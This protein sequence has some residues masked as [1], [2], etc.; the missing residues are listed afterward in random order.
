MPKLHEVLYERIK[1]FP[2]AVEKINGYINKIWKKI[3]R[4]PSYIQRL[5][6]F[7]SERNIPKLSISGIFKSFCIKLGLREKILENQYKIVEE[8]YK[9][10]GVNE[11]EIP[12]HLLVSLQIDYGQNRVVFNPEIDRKR[13]NL[14]KLVEI[15]YP[16]LYKEVKIFHKLCE[17]SAKDERVENLLEMRMKELIIS[18]CKNVKEF[19]ERLG[20]KP[21]IVDE[22]L[23]E[24]NLEK[25][26]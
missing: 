2:S 24:L 19:L 3:R 10:C 21:E 17:L 11:N 12:F 5:G 26:L 23:N 16:S 18:Q 7:I 8:E 9:R 25:R 4:D 22:A 14:L 15:L 13:E 20:A 1:S 6:Y